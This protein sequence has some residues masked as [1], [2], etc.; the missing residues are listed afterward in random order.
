VGLEKFK[1]PYIDLTKI[2]R[3]P[4]MVAEMSSKFSEQFGL[5]QELKGWNVEKD[6]EIKYDHIVWVNM[7]HENWKDYIYNVYEGLKRERYSASDIVILMPSHQTGKECV[8]M[9]LDKKIE[10]NHVFCLEHDDKVQTQKKAFWMGDGRLKICTIHS[11]KGWELLN[12][13]IFIPSKAPQSNEKL[14]SMIYTAITRTRGNLIVL[15]ANRRYLKF[16]E[17]YPKKYWT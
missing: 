13:V 16:G 9:F 1:D 12:I 5:D 3:L 7:K 15:N 17:K 11:F 2:Y 10:V 8:K 4:R 14:D 6:P